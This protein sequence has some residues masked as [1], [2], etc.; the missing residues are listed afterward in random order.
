MKWVFVF[1]GLLSLSSTS[2]GATSPNP[3]LTPGALCTSQDPNFSGYAYPEKIARCNRNVNDVEKNQVAQNYGSIPKDQ[4]PQYEFDHLIP[5][6]AGGSNDI[7]NIWPQPIAEAHEKDVLE[8]DICGGLRAGT[9][10][11]AE[12]LKKVNQ[13]FASRQSANAQDAEGL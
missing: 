11:Q 4:W 2:I 3:N 12:A 7:H 10:T 8:N 13:W 5:L 6:C 9:M 1:L